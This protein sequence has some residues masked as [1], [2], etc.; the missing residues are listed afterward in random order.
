M[1]S[2]GWSKIVRIIRHKTIKD[3][4][5]VKTKNSWVHITEDH[6][7]LDKNKNKIKP[8]DLKIGKTELLSVNG[9]ET[10]INIEKV[11]E[12]YTDYVYD[13]ETE[14]GTFQAGIGNLIV[15]NTD[16][17]FLRFDCRYPKGHEKEGEKMKG[18]DQIYDYFI[19]L[20][21]SEYISLSSDSS[22]N[23]QM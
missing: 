9:S 20:L 17:V 18:F 7:L 11:F 13:I 23:T 5:E 12:N 8:L 2:S 3:I 22:R 15:K 21:P 6:S 10:V 14:D 19:Y 1:T 4:Y 16:S